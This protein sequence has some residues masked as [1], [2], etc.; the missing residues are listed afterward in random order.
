MNEY[1]NFL[2]TIKDSYK[3]TEDEEFAYLS[4]LLTPMDLLKSNERFAR[5][6]LYKIDSE[7][8]SLEIVHDRFNEKD[9]RAL[10]VY[11]NE[12]FI[13]YVRKRFD[14]EY[15]D[16]TQ[17][18]DNFFF[19]GD[20]FKNL[21][22]YWNG[23]TF[24]IRDSSKSDFKKEKIRM[25]EN[26]K[27]EGSYILYG[28][29][30]KLLND[31]E[32]ILD[33]MAIDPY[34]TQYIGEE[35]GKDREVILAAISTEYRNGVSSLKYASSDLQD[36]EEIVLAA[37]KVKGNAI[38][39]ASN[40]LKNDMGVILAAL[41]NNGGVLEYVGDR[42]RNDKEFVMLALEKDDNVSYMSNELKA[43]KGF[44]LSIINK[45]GLVWFLIGDMFKDFAES[46]LCDDKDVVLAAVRRV[47]EFFEY[48]SMRLRA[49][50][51][52][53]LVAVEKDGMVI[54]FADKQLMNDKEVALVA[55]TNNPHAIYYVSTELQNDS[56]IK[57]LAG[58][59]GEKF[60]EESDW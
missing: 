32:F 42:L 55:I 17:I 8:I 43:D 19:D 49:D 14:N 5:A 40:R 48:V 37:I 3:E 59:E 45:F 1:D 25:L 22:M 21:E 29:N 16:N 31:K 20:K 13:G 46:K 24:Y 57:S 35:P 30:Y 28:A 41:E 50:K 18:V 33:A 38:Q 60:L 56:Y 51:E 10:E 58:E 27:R 11:Y 47:P 2:L 36:N 26:V 9:S 15:I 23:S 54:Q 7:Q 6:Q 53:A 44:V 4:V 12:T 34:A 39:Y 52:V